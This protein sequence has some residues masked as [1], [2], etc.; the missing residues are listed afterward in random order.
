[1]S[2]LPRLFAFFPIGVGLTLLIGLWGGGMGNPPLMFR[3]FGSF[4][5]LFFMMVGAG[6]FTTMGKVGDPRQMAQSLHEMT[7]EFAA[8]QPVGGSSLEG[9][10]G[11]AKPKVGYDCPNC[12]AAL[13]KEADVSPS[14]DVKCGYCERWFNVHNAG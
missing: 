1:M 6:I 12:G 2:L 13:G 7:K 14:G 9:H 11:V 5:A 10:E 8:N 3:V 4:V